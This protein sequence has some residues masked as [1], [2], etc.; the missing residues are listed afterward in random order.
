MTDIFI[1]VLGVIILILFWVMLYD[2]N[3]FV[4]AEHR[5]VDPRIKR[6]CRAVVLADLHNKRYGKENEK[7]LAA[8][9][10]LH[11]D[12]I[13]VAG[14]IPTAKPGKTLTVAVHLMEE[15]A[16]E[17]PVYYGSGNHE[18]RMKIYP[19]VY[20]DMSQIYEKALSEAG[21]HRL[22]ND[23]I[24]L[25]EYGIN[26]FGLE[27]DKSYYKR[28]GILQMDRKYLS[29]LMGE[30]AEDAYNILIAHNPDYFPQYAAWGSDL[31]L[32]GHIHGGMV[33]VPFW[34]KGV[35]SPN[36]RLFPRYDGGIFRQDKSVMLLSRGLGMHT[37]PIRLFNPG[38]LLVVDLE[39]EKE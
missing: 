1:T 35:V 11:P 22:I 20:G 14:D 37:I 26:I 4:V 28:F 2:S 6:S 3:R 13:L 10:E 18:Y 5:F 19:E 25:T 16:R 24:F 7:L 29:E 31:V 15:L 8:I 23:H 17:Y 33:R 34:G 30:P 21:V 12:I 32:S 38:E 9:H 36:I 27:I 39:P